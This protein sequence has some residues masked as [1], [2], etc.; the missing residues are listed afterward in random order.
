MR[1]WSLQEAKARFSE[2][3]NTAL[4]DGPQL[5]TRRGQDAVVILPAEQFT[6]VL[7][8]QS[9]KDFLLSAPRAELDVSRDTDSGR[10]VEL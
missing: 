10:E 9:L 7:G 4:E 5:V 6:G 1:T 2:L 3:V 8:S